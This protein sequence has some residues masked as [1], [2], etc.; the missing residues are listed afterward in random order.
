MSAVGPTGTEASGERVLVIGSGGREFSIAQTLLRSKN[1]AHVFVAPGNAGTSQVRQRWVVAS[2][3]F[4][5]AAIT[6]RGG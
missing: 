6:S 2:Y 5:L 3:L 1:V 4:S